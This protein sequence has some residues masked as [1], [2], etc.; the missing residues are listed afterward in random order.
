MGSGNRKMDGYVNID[1]DKSTNPDKIMN[2][3]R[4][5]YPITSNSVDEVKMIDVLEHLENPEKVAKEIHRILKIGGR[6]EVSVPYWNYTPSYR[7]N[8]KWQFSEALLCDLTGELLDS[9]IK[10]GQFR[11]VIFEFK[12]TN[13]GKMRYIPFKKYLR[14]LFCNMVAKMHFILEKVK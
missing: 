6:W 12:E 4:F 10:K 5:P 7:I 2:L 1:I 13:T 3:N 9:G 11:I 14:H 8:H